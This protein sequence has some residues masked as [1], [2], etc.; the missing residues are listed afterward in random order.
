MFRRRRARPRWFDRPARL[1][2][3]GPLTTFQGRREADGSHVL[4]ATE[5][6]PSLVLGPAELRVRPRRS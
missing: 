4:F 1:I 6:R 3:A 5:H 2:L